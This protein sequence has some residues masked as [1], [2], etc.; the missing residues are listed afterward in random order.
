[1]SVIN[2]AFMFYVYVLEKR[3]IHFSD[4]KLLRFFFDALCGS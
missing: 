4:A 1:M 2:V 3:S